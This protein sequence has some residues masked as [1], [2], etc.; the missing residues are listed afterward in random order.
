MYPSRFIKLNN[1]EV[2][3]MNDYY[4]L[5][6]LLEEETDIYDEANYFEE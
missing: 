2:I 1:K 6:E 4:S 5:D 3:P